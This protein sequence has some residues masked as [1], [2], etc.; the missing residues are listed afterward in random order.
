MKIATKPARHLAQGHLAIRVPL[1]THGEV[2]QLIDSFNQMAEDLQKTTVSRDALVLEVTERQRVQQE[3]LYAKDAADK[4]NRAKSA[5]LATM[6]HEL[7]TPL[8]SVIGFATVLLKN[9]QHTFQP[10]DLDYLQRIR[11]NGM[12]LLTLMNSVLDLSRVE[13]GQ[14]PLVLAPVALE[15]LLPDLLAQLDGQRPPSVT[16]QAH[17][18]PA[19]A[20]LCT[21]AGLL[22]EIGLQPVEATPLLVA[23][24]ETSQ[25]LQP[26][27][28][29]WNSTQIS[30]ILS[31][32]RTHILGLK[33]R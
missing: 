26:N 21:D 32:Q 10:R 24:E 4:A 25:G 20:P 11:T 15:R 12:H 22:T 5:F 2:Q 9:A 1:Q 33:T 3:L 23:V 28:L 30:W 18:P 8:N 7:R 16:L 19:L 14:M 29:P 31:R 6:S 17:V 27:V 13:A